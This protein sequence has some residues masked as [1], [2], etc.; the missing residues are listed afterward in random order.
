LQEKVLKTVQTCLLLFNRIQ[1]T[2]KH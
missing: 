2:E 1:D